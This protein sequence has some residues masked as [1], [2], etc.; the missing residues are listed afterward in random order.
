MS[1]GREH[2]NITLAMGWTQKERERRRLDLRFCMQQGG[3][4]VQQGKRFLRTSF[5]D[6]PEEGGCGC[7]SATDLALGGRAS[8]C[9]HHSSTRRRRRDERRA[10]CTL[11]AAA[12]CRGDVVFQDVCLP[13]QVGGRRSGLDIARSLLASNHPN[14]LRALRGSGRWV[15]YPRI[16]P[17][18][19]TKGKTSRVKYA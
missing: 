18:E 9:N 5:A 19:A 4:G 10:V 3:E 6:G 15:G 14:E 17:R 16:H 7:T 2:A 11:E 12:A 13:H 8:K 1:S